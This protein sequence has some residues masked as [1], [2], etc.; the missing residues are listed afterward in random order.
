[1]KPIP[2]LGD[3]QGQRLEPIIENKAIP[4]GGVL[5]V[6]LVQDRVYKGF[7]VELYVKTTPTIASGTPKFHRRGLSHALVKK[8]E[9]ARNANDILQV[10]Q[11]TAHVQDAERF[12]GG[13]LAPAAYKTNGT[14]LDNTAVECQPGEQVFG[15]TGQACVF[16]ESFYIPCENRL[17]STMFST[18]LNTAGI[19]TAKLNL[20]FN[21][22]ASLLDP[23]DASSTTF[24]AGDCF[25]TV[26][27]NTSDHLL[28]LP[29]ADLVRSYDLIDLGTIQQSGT[30]VELKPIGQIQTMYLRAFKGASGAVPLTI[31]EMRNF[32]IKIEYN[33]NFVY[34][35]SI[36]NFRSLDGAKGDLRKRIP[37]GAV[38]NLVNNGTYDTGLN[39]VQAEGF[40]PLRVTLSTPPSLA[41]TA[42]RL[43]ANYDLARK[44]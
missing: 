30:I 6:E 15:T 38:L 17:T 25:V 31:E 20:E 23:E 44:K 28:D 3:Y 39:T 37:D 42:I 40:K 8:I 27:G 35:G 7:L 1:M 10:V 14:S 11:G 24:A 36:E 33:G 13:E 41:G 22:L 43:I 5:P 19:N 18:L 12:N 32:K 29:V 34:S 21:T 4:L 9:L 26:L 16:L 2:G